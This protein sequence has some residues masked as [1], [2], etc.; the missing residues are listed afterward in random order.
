MPLVS[1]VMSTY[2]SKEEYLR[3][4]IESILK[5]S[6]ENFEFII[7]NDGSTGNDGDVIM[8]YND[9]RIILINN[10]SNI[11][12]GASLNKAIKDSQGKYIARMD[13][14]D[15]SCLNRLEKQ[16]SFM[17]NNKE[18]DII[19]SFAKMLGIKTGLSL[20][21]HTEMPEIYVSL[22]MEPVLLHPTVMIRKDFLTEND[23]MYDPSFTYSQDFDM[24]T[25][26]SEKG[27]IKILP[28]VLLY[29]RI[30]DKQ[31]SSEKREYQRGFAKKITKRQLDRFG[32]EFS[33][34]EFEIH[35]FLTGLAQLDIEKLSSLVKW[36]DKLAA[37][38]R[39]VKKY[40]NEIFKHVL[41]NRVFNK[42]FQLP[43]KKT[44]LAM[45]ALTDSELREVIFNYHNLKYSMIRIL[46]AMK[47]R[48]K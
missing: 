14:D 6:H 12:L 41:V 33:T 34:E 44:R 24:W 31:I 17:E 11:G 3:A 39:L 46:Y 48:K 13:S 5:Q 21:P 26:C 20:T 30:H 42:Y 28:E 15:L 18:V 23:L 36:I 32:I 25:R 45:I 10:D 16:V 29:L 9:G 2:N 38:N 8:S 35:S 27:I 47:N 37:H 7:V 19:G 43:Q 4:A 40:D 1:V 22:L